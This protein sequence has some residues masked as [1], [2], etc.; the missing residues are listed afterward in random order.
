MDQRDTFGRVFSPG[1][2]RTGVEAPRGWGRLT[3]T[4]GLELVLGVGDRCTVTSAIQR[5]GSGHLRE[6]DTG[7]TSILGCEEEEE[8]PGGPAARRSRRCL[9]LSPLGGCLSTPRLLV[10]LSASPAH[11]QAPGARHPPPL[12]RVSAGH[13]PSDCQPHNHK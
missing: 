4:Q 1:G 13:K 5:R 2:R 6:G 7:E 9:F 3:E 10:P 11:A 8:T 12:N